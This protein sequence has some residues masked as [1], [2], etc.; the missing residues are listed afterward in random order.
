MLLLETRNLSDEEFDTTFS[1]PMKD[2]TQTAEEIV[3]I[4]P[5]LDSVFRKEY[6]E[7]ETNSWEVEYVY[8]NEPE[9]HQHILVNTKMENIYLVVVVDIRSREIFG[10]HLLNLNEKYGL[11]H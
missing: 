10:H 3:E 6:S 7:T 9:T 5:Y 8:I 11:S 2:I 1:A 4:W